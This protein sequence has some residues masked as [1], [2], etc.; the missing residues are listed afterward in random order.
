MASVRIQICG[1]LAVQVDGVRVE[2]RLPSRQG[3]L[4]FAFLAVNRATPVGRAALVDAVW[5]ARP[6][7]AA[8]AALRALLSK[9]RTALGSSLVGGGET[10]RL[11]LPSDAFID[12]EAATAGLHRA[13]SAVARG[14]WTGGWA[15][16]RV[17]L[18]TC[19]RGFMPGEDAPW[20]QSVRR[21][22][23]DMRLRAL[24]AVAAI[25]LG[26]GGPE[27]LAAERSGHRLVELAPLR[28]SGWLWLMRAHAER[29]NRAEALM[30][31][32]RLR[33]MLRDELG[34]VPGPAL[35][36]LHSELLRG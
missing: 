3:R 26:M 10:P 22:L 21:R 15:P 8:D 33:R 19:E 9:V 13:E 31:Y 32:E 27:T 29:G 20:V 1:L 2:S 28:E 6:P 30:T 24:D 11:T 17:A 14:D 16:A 4:L 5:S 7:E 12:L 25:G 18:H 36:A 34:T 23:D 35:Q